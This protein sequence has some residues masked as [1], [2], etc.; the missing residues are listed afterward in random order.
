MVR[1]GD[2]AVL[3]GSLP[4]GRGRRSKKEITKSKAAFMAKV[5]LEKIKL[6]AKLADA[7]KE[8]ARVSTFPVNA[9]LPNQQSHFH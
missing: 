2:R 5:K 6:A 8:Q 4:S 9:F 1:Q 7:K 3:T